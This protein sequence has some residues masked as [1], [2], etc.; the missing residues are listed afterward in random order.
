MVDGI[1]IVKDIY[2][3]LKSDTLHYDRYENTN[4]FGE[5]K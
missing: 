4:A 3:Y 1:D 5:K 2:D